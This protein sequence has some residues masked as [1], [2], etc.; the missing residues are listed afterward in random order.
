MKNGFG[1]DKNRM[2][3]EFTNKNDKKVRFQTSPYSNVEEEFED[4]YPPIPN[5]NKFNHHFC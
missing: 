5:K 3:T 4:Y 1:F 2:S